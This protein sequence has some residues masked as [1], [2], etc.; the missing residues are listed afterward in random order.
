M[1]AFITALMLLLALASSMSMIAIAF[2]ADFQQLAADT[3]GD[4]TTWELSSP[5]SE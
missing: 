4:R 5:N 2:R 3:D 1:K